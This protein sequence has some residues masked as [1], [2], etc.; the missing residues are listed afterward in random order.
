LALA[1]PIAQVVA[2][3]RLFR[4]GIM[5]KD[6]AALE[7]LTQANTVVFDK[8]G[9]LTLGEPRISS[10]IGGTDQDHAVACCACPS[11]HASGSARCCNLARQAARFAGLD[12]REHPGFGLEAS[13]KG[14]TDPAGPAR[15][16]QRYCKA[17]CKASSK[18]RSD[19]EVCF[20]VQGGELVQVRAC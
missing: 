14:K 10:I 2:A 8:T 9:T 15:L 18:R 13:W 5:V 7:R 19:M 17:P 11:V 6:G 16:G 4:S 1:V 12:V 3:N 20:A